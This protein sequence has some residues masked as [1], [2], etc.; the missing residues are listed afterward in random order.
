MGLSSL[1]LSVPWK[2]SCL[3]KPSL[4]FSLT[5]LVVLI[6][7][8]LSCFTLLFFSQSQSNFSPLTYSLSLSCH[9]QY[10][11]KPKGKDR[12]EDRSCITKSKLSLMCPGH[13]KYWDA[14]L[15]VDGKKKPRL[16]FLNAILSDLYF[17]NSVSLK[18]QPKSFNF[19]FSLLFQSLFPYLCCVCWKFLSFCLPLLQTF[20]HF[21]FATSSHFFLFYLLDN[22]LDLMFSFV[23]VSFFFAKEN[24]FFWK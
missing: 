14:D 19:Q 20:L 3:A 21:R 9:K 15:R 2:K 12:S 11:H 23:V 4:N 13:T 5:S 22:F 17:T 18:T 8:L 7:V 10:W 1:H 6:F 16:I 24:F